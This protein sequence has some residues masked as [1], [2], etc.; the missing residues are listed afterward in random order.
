MKTIKKVAYIVIILIGFLL[1]LG[2][3]ESNKSIRKEKAAIL[4]D[5]IIKSKQII[6]KSVYYLIGTSDL[7]LNTPYQLKESS[8]KLPAGYQDQIEKM[9]VFEFV[10][11]PYFE[12]KITYFKWKSSITYDLN[13]G[14][15]GA[16]NNIKN[17]PGVEKITENRTYF[18]NSKI[19][20]YFYDAIMLRNSES[21][22]LKGAIIKSG[23]ETWSLNFG[24]TESK[25]EA[26]VNDILESIK[27]N[28]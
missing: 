27:E 2:L 24:I 14:M 9:E 25:N 22:I 7:R 20:A 21:A 5:K 23:Q 8:L 11:N 28:K 4:T 19:E 16:I 10:Q 18:K 13:S 17:L 1:Y 3:K 26:M 15:D 6:P 12:G